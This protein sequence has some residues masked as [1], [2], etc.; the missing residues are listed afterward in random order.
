MKTDLELQL[1]VLA[2]LGW[3]PSVNAAH[4]AVAVHDGVVTLGGQVTSF[5]EKWSAELAAQRV[6]GVKAITV[7]MDVT[8][9][10]MPQ[11]SDPDIARHAEAAL[12]WTGGLPE[13]GVHVMVEKGWITLSGTVHWDFQRQAALSAVR[14]ITGVAGVTD[15]IALSHSAVPG[16]VRAD[17]EA[18]FQRRA[19]STAPHVN[20]Q[21][22]GGDVTLTGTVHSWTER[23]LARHTAWSAPG[24][25]NVFDN[26]A[27]MP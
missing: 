18:A 27:V 24:V 9:A 5:S 15:R 19:R 10:G 14:H 12:Q 16:V 26:I 6:A 1:D 4:I 21:V 11:R 20:V 3:E 2:E 7:E 8:L 22:Q 25:R 23:N 13:K 17:I